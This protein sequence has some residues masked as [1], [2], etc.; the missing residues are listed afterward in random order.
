MALH[1]PAW[2]YAAAVPVL[3]MPFLLFD[4]EIALIYRSR[5]AL[6]LTIMLFRSFFPQQKTS[7]F[8]G[9]ASG[10][11]ATFSILR[12]CSLGCRLPVL[13]TPLAAAVSP[14]PRDAIGSSPCLI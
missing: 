2:I 7:Q 1:L 4:G 5:C 9:I 3:S 13:A 12:V 8:R 11:L 10:K 14:F 6:P